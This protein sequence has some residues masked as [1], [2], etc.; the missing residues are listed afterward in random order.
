MNNPDYHENDELYWIELFGAQV[1]I[2]VL[3]Q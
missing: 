3:V 2:A 1:L